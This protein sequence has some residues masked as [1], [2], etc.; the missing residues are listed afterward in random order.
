VDA[1]TLPLLW[2]RRRR[3]SIIAFRSP[4]LTWR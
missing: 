1:S 2:E 3:N 4:C